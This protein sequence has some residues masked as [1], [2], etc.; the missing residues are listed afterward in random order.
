MY[1]PDDWLSLI[2][3]LPPLTKKKVT[4]KKA[5]GVLW[6]EGISGR[7]DEDVSSAFVKAISSHFRDFSEVVMWLDNCGGQ[8]KCWTLYTSMIHLVNL[9]RGPDKITLK[10][11]TVG[12]TFMS[13]DTFHKMVEGEMKKMGK[14]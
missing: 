2:K 1:S 8:N 12:H 9:N 14:F 4:E 10:Y 6:H 3:L 13:A 11:F 7:N 5:L